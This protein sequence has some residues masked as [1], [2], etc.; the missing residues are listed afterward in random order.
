MAHTPTNVM[1]IVAIYHAPILAYPI[2]IFSSFN[3]A[4]KHYN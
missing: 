2:E 3:E 4:E 1:L